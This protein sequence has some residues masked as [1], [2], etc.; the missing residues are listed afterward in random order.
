[1]SDLRALISNLGK[2]SNLAKGNPLAPPSAPASN[3][4]ALADKAEAS[5]QTSTAGLSLN[6]NFTSARP[7]ALSD[8][9]HDS[10]LHL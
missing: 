3:A 4:K 6:S 2:D 1:M 8:A 9:R 7:V 10:G 5:S